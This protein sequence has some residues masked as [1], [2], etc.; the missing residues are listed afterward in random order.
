M[1]LSNAYYGIAIKQNSNWYFYKNEIEL[2]NN[3]PFFSIQK[4]I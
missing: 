3:F 2:K 1:E 4:H